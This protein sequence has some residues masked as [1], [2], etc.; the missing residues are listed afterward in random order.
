MID[1][2][3]KNTFYGTEDGQHWHLVFAYDGDTQMGNNNSG[4][5]TLDYGLEDIDKLNRDAGLERV[6][7]VTPDGPA[8]YIRQYLNQLDE[9]EFEM[10]YKYHLATCE[11]SDLL[12]AA[13]HTLDIL[14][15]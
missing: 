9:E 13:A 3:A 15:K 12:G 5:L 7:I 8:N 6:K 10:F 1:N 14:I 4:D 11:R 2:R